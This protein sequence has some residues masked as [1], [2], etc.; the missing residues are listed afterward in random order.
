MQKLE[1][2][3]RHVKQ[4]ECQNF[5]VSYLADQT[6]HKLSMYKGR[7]YVF[8]RICSLS[9]LQK[10]EDKEIASLGANKKYADD[11][12]VNMEGDK[13]FFFN[14][15]SG[16]GNR[17]TANG[18]RTG[19]SSR[20]RIIDHIHTDRLNNGDE[21]TG[22]YDYNGVAIL[23]LPVEYVQVETAKGN[24][25]FKQK[26]PYTL[27]DNSKSIQ[28]SE[29]SVRPEA[30]LNGEVVCANNIYPELVSKLDSNGIYEVMETGSPL[31]KAFVEQK[32][33][34][35]E[36]QEAMQKL[37]FEE[38]EAYRSIESLKESNGI[39]AV[40]D[41]LQY[42]SISPRLL[43]LM[44]DSGELDRNNANV[45]KFAFEIGADISIKVEVDKT[46]IN[47]TPNAEQEPTENLD[48]S[49]NTTDNGLDTE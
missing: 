43:S 2:A 28:L 12:S 27:P 3:L 49:L 4:K 38:Q 32:Q 17:N 6:E 1:D 29:S 22:S 20:I 5:M 11:P 26:S 25:T 24:M 40:Y 31:L 18:V 42:L 47:D 14:L 48:N 21:N 9:E 46:P 13:M 30:L 8:A 33:L 45:Q 7:A 35:L 23:V 10:I 37:S 39:K 16:E 15:D 36:A 34:E 19:L 44:V 41:Y